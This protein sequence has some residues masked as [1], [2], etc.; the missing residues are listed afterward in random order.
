MTSV[1][2][3]PIVRTLL[4]VFRCVQ[5]PGDATHVLQADPSFV[6]WDT[7]HDVYMA[8]SALCLLLFF[9]LSARMLRVLSEVRGASSLFSLHDYL[10]VIVSVA[11]CSSFLLG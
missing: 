2:F 6:C 4:N 5:E 9:V 11:S 3:I 1:L 10:N 8:F 7:D